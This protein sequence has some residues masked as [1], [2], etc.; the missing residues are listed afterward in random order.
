MKVIVTGADG[1]LGSN[2]VRLLIESDYEVGAFVE[3][4][5]KTP[6]LDN[7]DLKIHYGDILD[8]DTLNEAFEGY[9]SVI[10]AAAST[11]VWPSRS[12]KS[13]GHQL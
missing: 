12:K 1:L 7:L 13:L 8:V 11:S 3:K 10:H 4:G 2:L 6:T 9:D 5:K